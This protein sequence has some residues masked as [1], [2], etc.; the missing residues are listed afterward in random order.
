MFSMLHTGEGD[1][2]METYQRLVI[3]PT[4]VSKDMAIVC[5]EI[6]ILGDIV[7]EDDEFF[8]F[9]IVTIN[10]LDIVSGPDTGNV[11]ILDD[12]GRSV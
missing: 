10:P 1:Y 4:D 5:Q 12:D 7:I 9:N 2:N 8:K 6:T 11:T 3:S